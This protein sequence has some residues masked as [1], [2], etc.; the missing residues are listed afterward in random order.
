MDKFWNIGEKDII[1]GL[2]IL[3]ARRYDQSLERLW[4]SGITT[5][6]IRARYLTLLPWALTEF[7][8]RELDKVTGDIAE[9]DEEK[10]K[11]VLQRLEFI[12][13][14]SSKMGR[15]WGESGD[16]FGEGRMLNLNEDSLL[17][18]HDVGAYGQVMSS[19]YNSR[20]R[21]P[22]ILIEGSEIKIIRRRETFDDLLTQEK[23]V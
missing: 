11:S 22:E 19:N 9:F 12:V 23:D 20:A 13:F 6:S 3:G 5:I 1:K 7:Y 18:I 4:V 21:P 8:Q 2:D 17:A 14:V 16:T 10:F 15:E